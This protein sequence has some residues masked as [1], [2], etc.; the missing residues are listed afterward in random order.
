[1]ASYNIG[2]FGAVGDGITND[3]ASIQ[4]ASLR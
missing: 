4:A 3:A 1:M 2:D